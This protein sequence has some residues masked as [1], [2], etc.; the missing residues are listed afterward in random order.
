MQYWYQYAFII[1]FKLNKLH[2][3]YSPIKSDQICIYVREK[4]RDRV[5]M[6]FQR[7]EKRPRLFPKNIFADIF[8]NLF[9]R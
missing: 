1:Y 4:D 5:Y 6:I 9:L 7:I 2:N 8:L 3:V